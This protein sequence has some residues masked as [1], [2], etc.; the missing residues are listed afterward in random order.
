MGMKNSLREFQY[1]V[2]VNASREGSD[3]TPFRLTVL[4][5]TILVALASI[6]FV[7]ILRNIL[8]GQFKIAIFSSVAE[9]LVFVAYIFFRLKNYAFSRA[10]VITGVFT[11]LVGV[12]VQDVHYSYMWFA[13]FPAVSFIL[14][15][16]FVALWASVIFGV[17]IVLIE[18]AMHGHPFWLKFYYV[19]EVLTFYCFMVLGGYLYSRILEEH[20]LV[21]QKL[22]TRDMLTGAY[23]RWKFL[24]DLE[25]ELERARRYDYPVSLIMF[26]ID[27]FKRVN[28]AFGHDAG[29]RVLKKITSIVKDSIRKVDTLVRWGGEEFIIFL[30]NTD[31]NGAAVL[32]EKIRK[33]VENTVFDEVGRVTVSFGVTQL[34]RKDTVDELL[35]RVDRVLY[36][37]KRLGRNRV[38]VS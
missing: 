22:A 23:N 13:L 29:D 2:F 16:A 15:P 7:A 6:P 4:R 8:L 21:L 26:D 1:S 19:Q 10:F 20:E 25:N 28:D 35:K 5:Y 33:K 24:E 36:K 3:F 32:A 37:A 30:P 14:F 11:I 18:F 17:S 27:H 12:I 9:V 38:E 31:K 34:E